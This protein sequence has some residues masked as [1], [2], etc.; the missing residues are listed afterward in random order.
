MD[1]WKAYLLFAGLPIG[2]CFVVGALH[3][4]RHGARRASIVAAAFGLSGVLCWSIAVGSH[5]HPPGALLLPAWIA[6]PIALILDGSSGTVIPSPW[7]HPWTAFAAYLVAA[8][9]AKPSALLPS[10]DGQ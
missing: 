3:G 4:S 7:W 6:A 8:Q 10:D 1:A 2:V 9:L 5:G